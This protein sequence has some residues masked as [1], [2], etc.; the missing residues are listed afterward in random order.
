M[1]MFEGLHYNLRMFGVPMYDY[2]NVFYY[3]DDVYK[4]TITPESVINKNHHSIAY[5]MF[6]ETMADKPSGLL[7]RELRKI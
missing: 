3:N 5:H 7:R 6:K 2:N 4:N 1:E